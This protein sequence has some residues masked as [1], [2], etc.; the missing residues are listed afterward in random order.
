MTLV[1]SDRKVR[2]VGSKLKF[3]EIYYLHIYDFQVVNRQIKNTFK[4][5]AT[6]KNITIEQ[7]VYGFNPRKKGKGFKHSSNDYTHK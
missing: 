6:E 5:Q 2:P 7:V 4:K 3:L 1:N